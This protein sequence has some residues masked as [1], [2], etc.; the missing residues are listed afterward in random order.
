MGGFELGVG[1]TTV[2][3]VGA[4]GGGIGTAVS[5]LL[6]DAGATVLGIDVDAERL[7]VTTDALGSAA[8][9]FHGVLADA[10]DARAIDAALTTDER[11]RP[12]LRGLVHVVGGMSTA[13]WSPVTDLAPETFAAVVDL[14]LQSAFVTTQAVARRLVDQGSGGSIVHIASISALAAMP[15]GAPY[16]AAKAGLLALVRTAAVELGPAGVRVNAVAPGTVR[17]AK[18]ERGGVSIDSP[19]EQSAVP[20]RRRGTPDDV[21]GATLFLL[22]DFAGFV[23]GHTLVVDGGSSVRPSFLDADDLPVFVH[24]ADLRARLLQPRDARP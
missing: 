7:A 14:N 17:T 18:T 8:T 12:P 1:D 3:V 15:F 21:A 22:S 23:T 13:Q 10:T 4:G 2:V 16:A 6:V 9:R 11:A 20:L 5:S 19:E 24:D